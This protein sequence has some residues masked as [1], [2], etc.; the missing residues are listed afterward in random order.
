MAR[1][2]GRICSHTRQTDTTRGV[3]PRQATRE[4]EMAPSE[5]MPILVIS[6]AAELAGMHP[7][8]LRQ[9]D[10]LGL[11]VPGRAPGRGRRYSLRDVATLREIQR[12]SGRGHQPRRDQANP[13][14]R[15]RGAAAARTGRGAA[16]DGRAGTSRIRGRAEWRRRRGVPGPARPAG[17]HDNRRDRALASDAAP[18]SPTPHP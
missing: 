7:Q 4:V 13:R 9:Y 2:S 18:L 15:V 16:Q 12:L 10:R 6:I 8:T 17:A 3:V 1:T 5:E 14:P 11:V